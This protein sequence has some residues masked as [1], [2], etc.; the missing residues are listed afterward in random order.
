MVGAQELQVGHH[1]IL[2]PPHGPGNRICRAGEGRSL[3]GWPGG[4]AIDA[5][6]LSPAARTGRR[7]RRAPVCVP[8]LAQRGCV[9][10]APD[11]IGFEDRNWT[12]GQNTTW[13]ELASRLVR[14]R[15]LLAD[16]LQ[17]ISLALDVAC[18]LPEA[19]PARIGFLGHSYGGRAALWAPAW[20]ERITASVSSC[21]C[22]PYRDS[23]ARDAGFQAEFVV[24]AFAAD[25]DVEDVLALATQCRF[26]LI[27]AED[28]RW[29]RGARDIEAR[30]AARDAG[31]VRVEL[32]PGGHVFAPP[33]RELA[34]EFL[35]RSLGQAA[36]CRRPISRE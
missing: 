7:A 30:L 24:P 35:G 22:I 14:G 25:H 2:S 20:D 15:T 33:Q 1:A 11:A 18:A 10:V 32:V 29:S 8:E 17:E 4:H 23:F 9:T 28:D 16:C 19:D 5:G 27:A 36:P 6:A 31:H 3:V 34:Y 12:D 26:L 13:F 21:G